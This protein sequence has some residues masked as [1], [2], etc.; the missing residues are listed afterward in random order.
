ML[1]CGIDG[2]SAIGV[3]IFIDQ[4][5]HRIESTMGCLHDPVNRSLVESL[6]PAV[7]APW[8]VLE[9]VKHNISDIPVEPSDNGGQRCLLVWSFA[10]DEYAHHA[11]SVAGGDSPA[12]ASSPSPVHISPRR[13]RSSCC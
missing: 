10:H 2:E 11:D 3:A 13:K 9:A 4:E 6:S 7:E 8:C 5:D 1:L 12:S